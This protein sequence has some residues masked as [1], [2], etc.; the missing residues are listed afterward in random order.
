MF[1]FKLSDLMTLEIVR[2]GSQWEEEEEDDDD[3]D[4]KEQESIGNL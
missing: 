3:D 1:L 2:E 4:E